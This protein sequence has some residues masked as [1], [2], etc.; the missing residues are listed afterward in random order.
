MSN[1]M[2]HSLQIRAGLPSD[3]S[4]LAVLASQV[5]LHT[6]AT[7][8]ITNEIAQ[9]VLS[10]LT[11]ERFAASLGESEARFLVAEYDECLVGFAAVKFGALCPTGVRAAVELQT[12]Y[13][14]EH[15]IGHGIG[16]SLLLA[17]EARAREQSGSP[18]WL[19]VNAKNARAI[20]FYAHQGYAKVGTTY[21]I[22]GQ[23]RHENHVLVGG[24]A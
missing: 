15:F 4:R 19:T 22:L 11:V 12:L 21:F 6:Y 3:A 5:W 13:V 23:S 10:E 24:D 20:T 16:R 17:A 8:G 14:Q 9:Y 2:R 7:D 1:V 18:L